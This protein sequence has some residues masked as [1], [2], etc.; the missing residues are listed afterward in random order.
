MP[1]HVLQVPF[2][3]LAAKI[4]KLQRERERKKNRG[5]TGLKERDSCNKSTKLNNDAVKKEEREK[6]LCLIELI[7]YAVHIHTIYIC[8]IL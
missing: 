1:I 2:S 8:I 6:Y 3:L 4:A 5:K 7:T